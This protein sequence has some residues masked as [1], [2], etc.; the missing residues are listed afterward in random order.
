M[1]KPD[2]IQISVS[3]NKVL[4]ATAILIHLQIV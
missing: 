3:T 4:L 1:W 2:E